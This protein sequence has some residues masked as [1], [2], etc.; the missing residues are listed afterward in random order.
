[1]LILV[2]FF[3]NA[4][5][6]H[7]ER[8]VQSWWTEFW[9]FLV[10][11]VLQFLKTFV[12]FLQHH[13]QSHWVFIFFNKKHWQLSSSLCTD[14]T[15]PYNHTLGFRGICTKTLLFWQTID[16]KSKKSTDAFWKTF[17]DP[18]LC[19]HKTFNHDWKFL[20]DQVDH[21]RALTPLHCTEF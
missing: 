12:T 16:Q 14:S 17:E 2:H 6:I 7:Q 5:V 4:L 21:G 9:H 8:A 20:A 13:Q 19:F 11:L 10:V 3:S 18:K 15:K 1:M